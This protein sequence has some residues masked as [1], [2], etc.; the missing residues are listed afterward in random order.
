MVAEHT[1][2]ILTLAT[3]TAFARSFA[4]PATVAAARRTA[5]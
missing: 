5:S 4:R 3:P 1:R 2:F